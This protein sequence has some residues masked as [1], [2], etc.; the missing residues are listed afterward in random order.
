MNHPTHEPTSQPIHRGLVHVASR[1]H[2]PAGRAR[3]FNTAT[4]EVVADVDHLFCGGAHARGV[5]MPSVTYT[6]RAVQP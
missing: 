4:G 6:A 5:A 1:S 2:R 3:I